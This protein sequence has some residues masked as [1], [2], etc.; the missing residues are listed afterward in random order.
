MQKLNVLIAGTG[1]H[2][3]IIK[4]SKFLNKLYTTNFNIKDAVSLRFNTF[5]ELAEQCRALQIDAVIVENEKWVLEGIR[6]VMTKNN[7]NCVCASSKFTDIKTNINLGRKLLDKYGINIPDKIK[8]PSEFPVLVRGSGIKRIANSI[9][10]IIKIKEE[11][12]NISG[13]ISDSIFLEKYLTGEKYV[14]ASLFDGQKLLTFPRKDIG[15]EILSEYS[16]KLEN[17]LK[18]ENENFC[19]FINSELVKDEKSLYCTGFSFGFDGNLI[20]CKDILYIIIS[21][22]YQKLNEI[23]I[24]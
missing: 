14:I 13:E 3:Q 10:E 24:Q 6:D 21:A 19:G 18:G 8:Y 9:Q 15:N 4:K 16:I 5:Q 12:N 17:L 11:I 7:I 2:S 23:E 22:I 20:D 1:E